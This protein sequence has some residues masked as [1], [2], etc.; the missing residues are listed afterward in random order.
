M[1]HLVVPT[2]VL[3]PDRRVLIWNMACERLTGVAAEELI[4]TTDHWR[5]FYD[6]PRYCLADVVASGRTEDLATL[7]PSHSVFADTSLGLRAENWCVMPRSHNRL[8]LAIDS[9]PI[10]DD[11]GRLIAVVETLRDQTEQKLAQM[12]LE[13]LAV[14]DGLTGVANRR[15]FDESIEAEW[16]HARREHAYISLLIGDV[17]FFKPY[18]D[19]YG[20]QQGDDCLRAV[21]AAI[22]S[23]AYRPKD[24]AARYGGEEF[25]VIMPST[26]PGGAQQV[27]ERVRAAVYNLDI[28]HSGNK[29]WQRVTVSIGVASMIPSI[30]DNQADLIGSA[31]K[32]LYAAKHGGRNRVI[33]AELDL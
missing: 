21:A 14:K 4:G 29:P 5:A 32:S 15:C 30:H 1:Q 18:N 28:P 9:G 19:T 6:S 24:V 25:A 10:Y 11:D 3:D 16:L 20:H 2:F 33:S 12:A 22:D 26:D 7:Y 13:S 27:A 31:D 8:Y 23:Q 17:D